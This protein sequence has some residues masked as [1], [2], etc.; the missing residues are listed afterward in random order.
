MT[1]TNALFN[2][3]RVSKVTFTIPSSFKNVRLALVEQAYRGVCI[4]RFQ[5]NGCIHQRAGI[6]L[7]VFI[8]GGFSTWP[9]HLL[10]SPNW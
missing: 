6:Y 5:F 9:S 7:Y 2:S 10:G 1:S 4:C 8:N 3:L